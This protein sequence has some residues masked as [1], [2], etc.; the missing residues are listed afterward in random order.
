MIEYSWGSLSIQ[1]HL[2]VLIA[3]LSL[4]AII[5]FCIYPSF[6]SK[7]NSTTNID[8]NI[9]TSELI[10]IERLYFDMNIL[11]KTKP[12]ATKP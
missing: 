9:K 1:P 2:S 7:L 12:K 10:E 11:A 3:P 4:M 8:N 6:K 5:I